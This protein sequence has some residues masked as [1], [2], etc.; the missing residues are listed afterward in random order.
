MKRFAV[1]AG[2][3]AASSA[4]LAQP[5]AEIAVGG[6]VAV[7]VI[8]DGGLDPAT[9]RTVRRLAAAALRQR[10][11]AVLEDQ[12]F[13][14]V[15]LPDEA[16]SALLRERG[17][18]R[19]YALQMG[20][21]GQKLILTLQE[22]GTDTLE[23][24]FSTSLS[25]A[26]IEEADRILPRL[27]DAVLDRRQAADNAT[28][29]T[30]T[31]SEAA[32]AQTKS[33][34]TKI[35]L[36]LTF[37]FNGSQGKSYTKPFGLNGAI[38]YEI[39][40]WRAGLTGFVEGHGSGSSGFFGIGGTWLPLDGEISPYLGAALGYSS[41]GGSGGS[42]QLDNSVSGVGVLLGVG[43]EFLRLHGFRLIA[44]LDLLVPFY[45]T[46]AIHVSSRATPLLVMK[47]AF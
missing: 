38:G 19:L 15:R 40:H 16:T 41:I 6:P 29:N 42:S 4:A 21:L 11:L 1:L 5:A 46:S 44:G 39:A 23:N 35:S 22:L 17:A 27:V 37:G 26:A 14:E 7:M 28:F 45:D 30:V 43:L 25:I 36:G 2:L 32:P 24:R 9:V 33:G 10:G 12:R 13:A 47:I 34:T 18:A 8:E 3:L 20:K 31:S